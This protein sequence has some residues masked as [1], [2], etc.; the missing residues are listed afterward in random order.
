M[1]ALSRHRIH[2]HSRGTVQCVL[3]LCF[4]LMPTTD[5]P[6][7]LFLHDY[8]RLHVIWLRSCLLKQKEERTAAQLFC[9][10]VPLTSF[11]H[12]VSSSSCWGLIF[13]AF[14]NAAPLSSCSCCLLFV[15]VC[16]Y[17][18]WH[19]T[20]WTRRKAACMYIDT[21]HGSQGQGNVDFVQISS[22]NWSLYNYVSF[23]IDQNGI[24]LRKTGAQLLIAVINVNRKQPL[25]A[26]SCFPQHAVCI[27][28]SI[29]HAG[30]AIS[31]NVSTST[32]AIVA[33][34]FG[35]NPAFSCL[36]RPSV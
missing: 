34:R 27:G 18:S 8:R 19:I 31:Q 16:E 10:S 35:V 7:C 30:H 3:A 9:S 12:V 23:R 17:R 13:N 21:N 29:G 20:Q 25:F 26:I 5:I 1:N 15:V 32:A 4:S 14:E 22:A 28:H 6:E 33:S 11:V 24:I 36:L 2:T